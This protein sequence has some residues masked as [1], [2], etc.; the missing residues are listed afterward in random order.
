VLL[1]LLAIAL[2]ASLYSGR[3][4]LTGAAL[5]ATF[6]QLRM[7]RTLVAFFA[8]AGLAV[9]GVVLQGL[10]R[11]PLASPSILGTTSGALFG[12]EL[13][14][15][16][17]Y[18]GGGL[19]ASG[20]P[21]EMWMPLGC[22][23]GALISLT[24]V[25][26]LAPLR[27]SAVALL[28]TGFLLSAMF[29]S[30]ST[31]LKSLVQESWQLL[32]VLNTLSA[33]SVSGAGP[34]QSAL[35]AVL[36]CG[37]TLPAWAWARELDVLMSGEDEATS[38]GVDVPRL[39]VWIV[40]W[41]ALLTAG[42]VAVGASVTFVG[43]IVPHALRRFFGHSHRSLIPAAFLGGGIFLLGCDVLC[44]LLPLRNEVPLNVVT[45]LIGGPLFLRLLAKLETEGST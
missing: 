7:H 27:A 18:T 40:I 24:V 43:L 36:V 29:L 45:A 2:L 17:L 20:L 22:V 1:G 16:L 30:L 6:L 39:R 34:R 31:L 23:L 28:L 41:T 13:S 35:A 9:G 25:L 10:F 44:R 8:G 11:N 21:S 32:R 4:A 38:L 26:G 42:A 14:L 19:A 33:G 15:V 12:G 37:S 3:G 5:D